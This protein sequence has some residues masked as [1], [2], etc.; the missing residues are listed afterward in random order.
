MQSTNFL[1]PLTCKTDAN[2]Q[3]SIGDIEITK[4]LQEYGSPLYVLCEETVRKRAQ[5][6]VQSLQNN[7]EADSLVIFASKS[8]NC[9]ATCAIMAQEGLGI[10]VVSAATIA[11][12]S[13]Y[14]Q[15]FNVIAAR[16]ISSCH[17]KG[18]ARLR[19]YRRQYW[20][21]SSL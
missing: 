2:H 21:V 11:P 5:E 20:V 1:K 6:Y 8:L 14:V 3:I 9:K 15:S 19:L 18:R 4:L 17:S 12:V 13:S 16:I 7:Y 10:D